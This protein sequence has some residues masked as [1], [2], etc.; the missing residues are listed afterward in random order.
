LVIDIDSTLCEVDGDAQQ[1]AGF[2]YTQT[3]EH[4][5]AAV[6]AQTYEHLEQFVVDDG[7]TDNTRVTRITEAPTS[8]R[9][10]CS[11]L[12]RVELRNAVDNGVYL[13]SVVQRPAQEMP[14]CGSRST[15]RDA[16][17]TRVA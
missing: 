6:L 17:D 14:T 16:W 5:I 15:N 8:H 4:G 2:G 9:G 1:G 13:A 12:Q 11:Q 10:C 7:S 3:V